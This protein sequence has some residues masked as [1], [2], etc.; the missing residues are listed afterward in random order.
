MNKTEKKNQFKHQI[1]EKT[2][3]DVFENMYF[4]FPELITHSFNQFSF[5]LACYNT[6]VSL[7][8]DKTNFY[9]FGAQL[10]VRKMAINFLGEERF[11]EQDELIDVFKEA[12]NVIVGNFISTSNVVPDIRF[13][14]PDVKMKNLYLYDLDYSYDIDLMYV[15]ENNFFRIAMTG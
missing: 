9:L 10:L 1:L 14:I 2:I 15:I 13:E 4:M 7:V 8:E 11:F 3:C 12:T 6:E 5:P